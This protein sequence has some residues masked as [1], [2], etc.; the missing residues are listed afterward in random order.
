MNSHTSSGCSLSTVNMVVMGRGKC[1]GD[2]KG[3]RAEFN[4]R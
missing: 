4:R 1:I 3:A 2:V